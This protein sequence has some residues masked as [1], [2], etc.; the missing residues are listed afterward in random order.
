MRVPASAESWLPS[1]PPGGH[2]NLSIG[3]VCTVLAVTTIFA[4]IWIT[5]VLVLLWLR[6]LLLLV[7]VCIIAVHVVFF[8]L[9]LPLLRPRRPVPFRI[10]PAALPTRSLFG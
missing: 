3:T 10:I 8:A 4:S 9:L 5:A 1:A 2:S 6:T 7:Q